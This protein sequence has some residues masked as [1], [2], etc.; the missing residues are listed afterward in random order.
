MRIYIYIYIH[1]KSSSTLHYVHTLHYQL[2][3]HTPAHTPGFLNFRS[4]EEVLQDG[5]YRDEM[6]TRVLH[7]CHPAV[8]HLEKSCHST[9]GLHL[10]SSNPPLVPHYLLPSPPP[11]PP[12]SVDLPPRTQ[13]WYLWQLCHTSYTPLPHVRWRR[14]TGR[15]GAQLG[16]ELKAC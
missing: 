1:V 14:S 12:Q 11:P 3:V 6:T 4:N 9:R 7:H 2:L 8:P 10:L 15:G 16:S 5:D 13:G